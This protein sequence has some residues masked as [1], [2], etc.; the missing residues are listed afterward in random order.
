MLLK[1]H[2]AVAVSPADVR[3]MSPAERIDFQSA[4]SRAFESGLQ[5]HR[6]RLRNRLRRTEP[7][8]E[9]NS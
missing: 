9:V 8:A 2:T 7:Q 3:S 5:V 6:N 4:I 1:K